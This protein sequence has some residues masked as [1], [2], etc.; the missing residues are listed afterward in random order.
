MPVSRGRFQGNGKVLSAERKVL[1]GD[2]RTWAGG[3][4][5]GPRA[6]TRS[7]ES[8]ENKS[9]KQQ[10]QARWT[11]DMPHATHEGVIRIGDIEITCA[12][13]STGQRVFTQGVFQRRESPTTIRG[14]D[15]LH[16]Q[17]NGPSVDVGCYLRLSVTRR[18]GAIAP[19]SF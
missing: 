2:A 5:A 3:Q 6:G 18:G 1:A 19:E 14:L 12:V 4:K 11:K 13:L 17:E 10:P 9:P 8:G 15:R 16:G 7:A